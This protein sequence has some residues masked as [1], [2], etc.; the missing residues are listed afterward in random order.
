MTYARLQVVETCKGGTKLKERV[1]NLSQLQWW[2][3][4]GQI[5]ELQYAG[6]PPVYVEIEDKQMERL[7]GS[8]GGFAS[9]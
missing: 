4:H 1:F 8:S 5:V 6:Q 2:M 7:T 3:G 9:G